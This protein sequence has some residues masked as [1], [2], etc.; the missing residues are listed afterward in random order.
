MTNTDFRSLGFFLIINNISIVYFTNAN[1]VIRPNCRN[2]VDQ[3]SALPSEL[4]SHL[5]A[6]HIVSS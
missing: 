3:C 6:G 5:G 2:N 4:S 1:G